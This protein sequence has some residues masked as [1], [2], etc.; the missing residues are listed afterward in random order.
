NRGTESMSVRSRGEVGFQKD[1]LRV[2]ALMHWSSFKAVTRRNQF[3]KG[4]NM[5]IHRCHACGGP[6]E[7]GIPIG[8]EVQWCCQAHGPW[9]WI[10][11]GPEVG[12]ED[13]YPTLQSDDETGGND[14][15]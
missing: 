15:S 4:S 3:C 1:S 12:G 6:A 8:E 14:A 2:R 5:T 13:N 9:Q 7:I 10:G 11:C